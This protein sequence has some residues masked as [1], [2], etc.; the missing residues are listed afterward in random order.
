MGQALVQSLLDLIDFSFAS[1]C[2]IPGAAWGMFIEGSGIFFEYGFD[3]WLVRLGIG[4]KNEFSQTNQREHCDLGGENKVMQFISRFLRKLAQIL[5]FG[6]ETSHHTWIIPIMMGIISAWPGS[7]PVSGSP[8]HFTLRA[9]E[10]RETPNVHSIVDLCSS[11]RI[12]LLDDICR[13]NQSRQN[14]LTAWCF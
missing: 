13:R 11:H 5:I 1:S 2:P 4:K 8:L 10:R 12:I 14:Q 7:V 9:S 3:F 6:F